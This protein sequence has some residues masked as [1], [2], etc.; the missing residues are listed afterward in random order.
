MNESRLKFEKRLSRGA[1][2]GEEGHMISL[3]FHNGECYIFQENR[4][5]S[6][7][8]GIVRRT[9]VHGAFC[10]IVVFSYIFFFPNGRF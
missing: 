9:H 4:G 7:S 6:S 8:G 1:G 5:R 3:S 2:R 10:C